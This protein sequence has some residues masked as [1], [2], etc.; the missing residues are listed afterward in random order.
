MVK[1]VDWILAVS[2]CGLLIIGSLSIYSASYNWTTPLW[3]KQVIWIVSGLFGMIALSLINLHTL[4]RNSLFIYIS[5]LLLLI[6]VLFMPPIRN[7]SSW[8]TIGGISIQPSELAKLAVI[9]MLASYLCDKDEA[10]VWHSLILPGIIYGIPTF[11]IICQPDVGTSLSFI[12]IF[13]VMLYLTEI[14]KIPFL[15]LLVLIGTGGIGL[16]FFSLLK[17]EY[18]LSLSL[19]LLSLGS[20][21]TFLFIIFT[22][23]AYFTRNKKVWFL[24]IASILSVFLSLSCSFIL[25]PYQEKRLIV[26]LKPSIDPLDAGYNIIQSKIAIGGGGLKG[27]GFLK[28]TQSHLGFL[29]ERTTD[30]IFSVWAEEFGFIGSMILLFFYGL[31]VFRGL[32][33]AENAGDRF[34]RLLGAGISTMIAVSLFVNIGITLGIL[35]ATGIP[36]PFV[37]YGGSS[38]LTN[39]AGVG[40]LLAI[41]KRN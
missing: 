27:M 8:F 4:K 31:L 2:L 33:I 21:I 38:L 14:K 6:A 30:F 9:I 34:S 19:V 7:V 24:F 18:G 41:K 40:L 13:F 35:P 20:I 12:S 28:G 10:N 32:E 36:L 26:F 37:S 39:M 29:P 25:K 23:L 1:R 17:F 16:L 11:L 22:S 3:K 5:S 15:F